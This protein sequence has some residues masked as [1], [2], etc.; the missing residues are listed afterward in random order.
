MGAAL[1]V[2]IEGAAA[3]LRALP[4]AR[5]RARS[6]RPAGTRALERA[7]GD[8][9]AARRRPLR[10]GGGEPLAAAI[11]E[12]ATR[13]GEA[14]VERDVRAGPRPTVTPVD[15]FA[16]GHGRAG[17]GVHRRARKRAAGPP[18]H[19]ARSRCG[20]SSEHLGRLGP[21]GAR[22]DRRPVVTYDGDE[23]ASTV[24]VEELATSRRADHATIGDR[25]VPAG[26]RVS[27][28]ERLPCGHRGVDAEGALPLVHV[29]PYDGRCSAARD[30]ALVAPHGLIERG[31]AA[32]AEEASH[33]SRQSG[34]EHGPGGLQGP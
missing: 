15:P 26:V 25:C 23:R 27:E 12:V 21:L 32:D 13:R 18:R 22:C 31:R 34:K 11:R 5:T 6:R 30:G 28:L 3:A 10:T 29:D 24:S 2:S 8:A 19:R 33:E 4:L 14:Q 7:A 20:H 9:R 1:R 17:C 16:P